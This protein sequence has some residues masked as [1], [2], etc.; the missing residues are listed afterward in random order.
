[1]RR[2]DEQSAIN[3]VFESLK[4]EGKTPIEDKSIIDNP[5]C[6][7][8]IS[9]VR[10]SADCTNLNLESLLKWS[11]SRRRFEKGKDY[12]I[13]FAIEPHYWIKKSIEGKEPKIEKYR[14]NGNA[15]EVWL[16]VHAL[17]VPEF[18]DCTESTIA[19]MTDALRYLNPRFDE[20]WFIHSQYPATRLWKNG[21]PQITSFPDWD[22][23]ENNYPF[24]KIIQFV[25]TITKDGLTK[26]IKFGG[27]F[28]Q[29]LIEPLNPNWKK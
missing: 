5:D 10:I 7:F 14:K 27:S 18:F 22:T 17:E 16:F 11:N 3:S 29:V 19:I 24:E 20:V 21:D 9:N 12:E 23:T 4:K 13:K 2:P 1:M 25:D 15:K 8:E 6:V 28:E 26:E